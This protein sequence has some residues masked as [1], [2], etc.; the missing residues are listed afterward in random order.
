[1]LYFDLAGLG[2]PKPADNFYKSTK[3]IVSLEIGCTRPTSAYKIHKL[4]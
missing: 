2:G 4:C 1:M 3:T